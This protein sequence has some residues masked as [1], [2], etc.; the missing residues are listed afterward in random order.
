MLAACGNSSSGNDANK[1]AATTTTTTRPI[2]QYSTLESLVARLA[3]TQ[4]VC[5][6]PFYALDSGPQ[7]GIFG[8]PGGTTNGRVTCSEGGIF[9]I[10]IGDSDFGLKHCDPRLDKQDIWLEGGNWILSTHSDAESGSPAAPSIVSR[11]AADE[12]L[13]VQTCP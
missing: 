1:I 9:F 7:R 8:S 6:K 4:A 13:K 10:D 2:T 3:S 11:I 5:L 12:G